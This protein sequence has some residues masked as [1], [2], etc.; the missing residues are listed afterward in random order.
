V[1]SDGILL[2]DKPAG[3]TSHDVVALVKRALG[4]VIKVGHAGTLDRLPGLLIVLVGRRP[5]QRRLMELPSYETVIGS[6]TSSTKTPGN[7]AH[8]SDSARHGTRP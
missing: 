5:A 8:Q 7:R 1:S 4:G 3:V 2:I 6:A